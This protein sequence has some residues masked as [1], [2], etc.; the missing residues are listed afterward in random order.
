MISRAKAW[1]KRRWPRLTLRTY[2]FASFFVVAALPGVGAVGLRVYENTL[3]RQT[4]GE[5][6][7]QGAALA[8][9]AATLWPAEATGRPVAAHPSR[10]PDPYGIPPDSDIDL[11]STPILSP[12]PLPQQTAPPASDAMTAAARLSP[13]LRDT[14]RDTYASIILLDRDGRAVTGTPLA[15]SYAAL[16]EVAAALEGTPRTVLR[17]NARFHATYWFDWLS[18]AAAIR[19]HHARPVVV[20]GRV[21]GVL[22]LSRSARSL[23]AGLY[24]DWGKIAL[25]VLAILGALV[26]LS[27]LLSRGIA[28]PIAILRAA[29]RAVASGRGAVPPAPRTAAIEIQDLY[30]DFAAM[31]QVIDARARYLRDFAHAVS[32]EFKTPLAGIRGALELLRDHE[33][34]MTADERRRFL[35]NADGDAARLTTLVTR[36]LELARADMMSAAPGGTTDVVAVARTLADALATRRVTITVRGPDRALAAVPDVTL[37]AVLATLIDNSIQAG[38]RAITI[39]VAAGSDVLVTVADDG[40]GIAPADRARVFEPFFT[41]RRAS[42]GTG[43]GLAIARSLLSAGG[44]ELRLLDSAVGAAF[45][46]RL[47]SPFTPAPGRLGA[48]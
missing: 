14:R 3:V 7:A 30:R 43:L 40:P 10:E 2:L 38:A 31:A 16:P 47:P 45:Q 13:I 48:K 39:D 17:R 6:A 5:L 42:G 20:G 22:L 26:L 21:V 36:L 23:F 9:S 44:G 15:G 29:T 32:H 35:A 25:G 18:R 11:S 28:R 12:R 19:V 46:L 27:G 34:T 41:S 24:A 8:A 37:E 4:E 33:E 1:A